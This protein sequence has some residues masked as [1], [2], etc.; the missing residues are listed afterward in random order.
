MDIIFTQSPNAEDIDCIYQGLSDFNQRFVPEI[1]DESFAIFVR[2]KSGISQLIR[3]R[4]KLPN[5]M[6]LM[7]SR[8]LVVIRTIW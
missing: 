4:F 6:S 7:V 2:D 1:T 8:K 3:I 5:F